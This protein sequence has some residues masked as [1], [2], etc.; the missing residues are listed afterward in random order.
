[1][2]YLIISK[3]NKNEPFSSLPGKVSHALES[4]YSDSF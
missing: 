2:N 4:K 3:Q 1:M